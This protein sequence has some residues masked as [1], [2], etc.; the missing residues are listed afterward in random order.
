MQKSH[1][2]LQCNAPHS[3]ARAGVYQT[4][5]GSFATPCFMPIGTVGAIKAL[6]THQVKDMGA[7]IILANT[8]HLY[9]RPGHKLIQELGGLHKYMAWDGPILTDSGGFQVFSLAK[10]AKISEEGVRF[11]SHIDGSTH[12]LTPELVV[13]IQE[14][15]G[16]DIMMPLDECLPYP[17]SE[18]DVEKS[19]QRTLAWERR[20]LAARTKESS[21]LFAIVQGGMYPKW[22]KICAEELM[23]SKVN[24]VHL[25]V[26][27]L[28]FDAYAIGG[29]SVG[30]PM[31]LAYEIAGLTAEVL[32]ED[33]PRYMMGV[34]MPVDMITAIGL[35]IDMFDCVIPT[36]NARNGMLF[37]DFGNINI[38]NSCYQ[39]DQKPIM[40]SCACYTCQH[41]SRAYL[42]HISLAKE[43]LSAILNSIHNLHYYISLLSQARSKIMEG[44]Y[45][46]FQKEFLQ[47]QQ[48]TELD[49]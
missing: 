16:S 39:K 20:C 19:L 36:R 28:G 26:S 7:Q 23:G 17:A 3:Q 38:R 4:T 46:E 6:T 40:A 30:E 31:E 33:K 34:G 43:I 32:P 2:T 24:N 1:F 49:L 22:R 12:L 8:Y 9:L 48:A 45:A 27:Q 41:Y 37:T 13:E 25:G 42:R 14:S 10:L 21:H 5:H 29:L 18:T 44:Q 47:K 15:L 11:Q 35:G